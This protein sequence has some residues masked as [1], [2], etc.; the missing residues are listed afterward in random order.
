MADYQVCQE[1]C[2]LSV[3]R[4]I[5]GVRI[6]QPSV[7]HPKY[8]RVHTAEIIKHIGLFIKCDPVLSSLQL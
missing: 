6:E 2:W 7:T 4:Y 1:T 8:I 3:Q 5:K